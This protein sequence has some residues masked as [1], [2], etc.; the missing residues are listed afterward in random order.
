M[1]PPKNFY[2]N[3][4]RR[5]Q[6]LENG[7]PDLPTP[8]AEDVGKVMK[9]GSDGDYE[10]GADEGLPTDNIPANLGILFTRG[11]SWNIETGRNYRLLSFA[12]NTINNIKNVG[13]FIDPSGIKIN[14]IT[15]PM[16]TVIQWLDDTVFIPVTFNDGINTYQG[17]YESKTSSAFTAILFK[18]NETYRLTYSGNAVIHRFI[19]HINFEIE[20][21]GSS[22]SLPSGITFSYVYD[23]IQAGVDVKFTSG[24]RIYSIT[25]VESTNIRAHWISD[26]DLTNIEVYVINIASDGTGTVASA[27]F[28]GS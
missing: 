8:S 18:D 7:I 9:V 6:G 11:S 13:I 20:V 23:L 22:V 5:K 27:T 17:F 26:L 14:G 2:S 1:K 10:L 12:N 16:P 15:T 25:S 19:E 24:A 4:D 28:S 3:L 21:S